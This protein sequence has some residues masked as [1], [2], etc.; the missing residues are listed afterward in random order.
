MRDHRIRCAPVDTSNNRTISL[1]KAFQ[2]HSHGPKTLSVNASI[3]DGRSRRFGVPFHRIPCAR[4]RGG[5]VR[6]SN[7]DNVD[8]A[9]GQVFK[10]ALA[11]TKRTF[12]VLGLLR[13]LP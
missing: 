9:G 12:L 2:K 6:G 8:P 5:Y 7:A 4:R 11:A 13:R 10:A 1:F 3:G